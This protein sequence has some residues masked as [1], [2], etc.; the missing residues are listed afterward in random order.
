MRL[1]GWTTALAGCIMCTF[2]RV[3]P[4]QQSQMVVTYAANAK[5]RPDSL[6]S[7]LSG[8]FTAAQA[9]RGEQSYAGTCQSCHTPTELTGSSFLQHW[10][11]HPLADLYL[12][13]CQKMPQD[14]PGS[15]DPN[16]AADIVAYLLKLNAM[17]AGPEELAAD[18][19][20]L[21]KILFDTRTSRPTP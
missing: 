21:K 12:Y 2:A 20:A 7:S 18:S 19:V 9:K 8:V 1:M 17:P 10:G 6:R 11:A 16:D 3:A 13:L 5:A 4:A 15:L 14:N